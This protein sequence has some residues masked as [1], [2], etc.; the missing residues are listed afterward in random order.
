MSRE[1]RDMAYCYN[2]DIRSPFVVC[3]GF[4]GYIQQNKISI[5][6]GVG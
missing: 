3:G 1:R 6:G 5:L 4:G 2:I